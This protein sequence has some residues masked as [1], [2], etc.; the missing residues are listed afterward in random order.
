MKIEMPKNV[1]LKGHGFSR[2][3]QEVTK[4]PALAAEGCF[5]G[6]FKPSL[7]G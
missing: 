3:G 1:V 2:A 6:D 5:W 7:G 4:T